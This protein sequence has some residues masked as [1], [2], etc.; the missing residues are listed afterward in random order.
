MLLAPSLPS[1]FCSHGMSYKV[2]DGNNTFGNN[3]PNSVWTQA[4][5]CDTMNFP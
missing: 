1:F 5:D 3:F 2:Y 4:R